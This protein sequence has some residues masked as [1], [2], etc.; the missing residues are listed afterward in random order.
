MRTWL[1]FVR[2]N[3]V[4]ALGIGVQLAALWLLAD[5]AGLHYLVAT[6]AAV[7]L[8][9]LHNFVWHWRWTW[10]DRVEGG[11]IVPAFLR[12]A[13]ANGAVSLLGNLGVM[14]TLVSGGH[15]HPVVANVVAIG[16]SGLLNF[17][18]GNEV[19]FRGWHPTV[20]S[21]D[22]APVCRMSFDDTVERASPRASAGTSRARLRRVA[23]ARASLHPP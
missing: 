15:L 3:A 9:V 14:T 19:V 10:R 11:A 20:L 1:R 18:V 12:F 7:G 8:V 5:V 22:N 6:M 16:V 23:P 21:A 4:G 13:G 2:F 17:W